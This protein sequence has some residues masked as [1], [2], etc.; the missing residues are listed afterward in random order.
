VA[1]HKQPRRGPGQ[2]HRDAAD[3]QALF[4]TPVGIAPPLTISDQTCKAAAGLEPKTWKRRLVDW[5]VPHGRI[6]RRVVCLGSDW[7][8][9]VARA[10]GREAPAPDAPTE[11]RE[12]ARRRL[13]TLI[14]GRK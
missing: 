4:S 7:V 10:I 2:A 1:P 14:E 5:R 8:D 9:A 11:T 6:G 12:G 13:R 3:G